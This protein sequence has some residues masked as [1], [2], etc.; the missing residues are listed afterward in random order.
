M[1]PDKPQDK[2]IGAARG[3]GPEHHEA[4]PS[5]FHIAEKQDIAASIIYCKFYL[6]Q[7]YYVC[8]AEGSSIG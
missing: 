1:K 3:L 7:I 4:E 2:F 8:E 6:W 5:P